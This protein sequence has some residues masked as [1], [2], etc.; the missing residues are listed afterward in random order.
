MN[1]EAIEHHLKLVLIQWIVIMALLTTVMTGPL[2][3][4]LLPAEL[5]R[6][7]LAPSTVGLHAHSA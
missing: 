6:R 1:P 4:W 7:V 2:L 5:K 3:R